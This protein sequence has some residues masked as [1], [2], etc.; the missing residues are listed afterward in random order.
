LS[1]LDAAAAIDQEIVGA[2][3]DDVRRAAWGSGQ[4]SPLSPLSFRDAPLGA[5]A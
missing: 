5:A 3:A 4:A 1:I 2:L